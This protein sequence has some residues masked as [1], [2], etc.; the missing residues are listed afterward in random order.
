MTLESI[1]SNSFMLPLDKTVVNLLKKK[2]KPF[3]FFFNTSLSVF[4][5]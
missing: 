1:L 4:I 2:K 5:F 3:L